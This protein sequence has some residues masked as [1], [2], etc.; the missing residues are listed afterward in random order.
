MS[1]IIQQVH[2]S[3]TKDLYLINYNSEENLLSYRVSTNPSELIVSPIKIEGQKLTVD[4]YFFS[5]FY[6]TNITKHEE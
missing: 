5:V 1:K 4:T 2:I 3:E 6:L